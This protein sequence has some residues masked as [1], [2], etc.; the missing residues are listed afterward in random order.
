ME[1][2]LEPSKLFSVTSAIDALRKGVVSAERLV[3]ICFEK[4]EKEDEK[5]GAFLTL[6]KEG[7]IEKARAIDRRKD[8]SKKLAGIPVAIKDVLSTKG[9]R[10]TAGS[11]MLSDYIPPF[12]ATVVKRLEEEGAIIIGKTNCDVFAFGASG[13]NS[14]FFPTKNP[15]DL[16]RV[17]G[18][19]S[20]GSAAAVAANECLFALGTDTGGSIRQPA[21]FCGDVGVKPTYGRCSRYGLIAMA[22]SFDCPG[23]ITKTVE[24][25]ALVL[26]V[27]AGHDPHDATSAKEDVPPFS[28][29]LA[30]TDQEFLKSLRIGL[31][32]QYFSDE[33][34]KEVKEAVK[35]AAKDLERLGASVDWVDLPHTEYAIAVYYMIVPSEISANMARYDGIRFGYQ[36]KKGKDAMEITLNS[37]SEA[38]EEEVKRRIMIGTHA[39]ST[40]YFDAYYLKAAKVRTLIIEDFKRV[41]QKVDVLLSPVSP[42]TAFKLGEKVNDPLKMYLSDIF[43]VSANV[44]GIP[45]LSVPY[46]KD[47]NNLPIGVQIMGKWFDEA[48]I[49]QVGKILEQE[50]HEN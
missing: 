28:E 14:G 37:R 38:L 17:P 41:F 26:E 29:L 49:L 42:T 44:A 8:Y 24:D 11:K 20:S 12:T 19:S 2:K 33:T 48:T 27:M 6:N 16:T 5:I 3:E 32:R 45:A 43:T 18:G 13:E 4:I 47:Q 10:T 15:H 1:V 22:S 25:A 23:P 40:G 35:K 34:Q 46:G 21:S 30:K 39:L 36:S 31:P 9:I 50:R 7:A